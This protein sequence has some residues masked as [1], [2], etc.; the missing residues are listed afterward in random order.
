MDSWERF[1]ETSLPDKKAFYRELNLENIT[2]KDY[3]HAQKV[4]EVFI[5]LAS[6]MTCMFSVIHYCLQMFLKNLETHVLKYMDLIPLISSL[7]CGI[8][9]KE[10]YVIQIRALK[11]AL[12]HGLILKRVHRV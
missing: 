8:E 4:W 5:I 6:I 7:V 3:N 9:D 11:Q 1:E 2:D 12:N 10:T